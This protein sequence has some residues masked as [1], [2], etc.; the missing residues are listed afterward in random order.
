MLPAELGLGR[1]PYCHPNLFQASSASLW[2]PTTLMAW[3]AEASEELV[4]PS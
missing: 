2:H 1:T 3:D 4:L